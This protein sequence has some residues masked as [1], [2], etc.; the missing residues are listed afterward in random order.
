MG[1]SS[2]T[3]PQVLVQVNGE[4][5]AIWD[6]VRPPPPQ[7]TSIIWTWSRL[8]MPYFQGLPQTCRILLH[9]QFNAHSDNPLDL[10]P[11]F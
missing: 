1:S 5:P 3:L 6:I 9:Q 7:L 10:N 2:Q 8:Q 11:N 4:P